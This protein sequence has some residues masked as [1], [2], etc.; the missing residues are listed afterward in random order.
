M[1]PSIVELGTQDLGV[2][3]RTIIAMVAAETL[4]PADEQITVKIGDNN[5]P[6][7]VPPAVRPRLAASR[8]STRKATVNALD[9][10]VRSGRVR[11]SNVPADQLEAVDGTIRVKGN[12]DKGMS[13]KQACQ[14][15][16]INADHR[17]GRERSAQQPEA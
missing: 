1:A 15:L 17:D 9:K 13:W 3:T 14:K 7:P 10:A 12:P 16:G 8:S 11:R 6:P 5:I 2:G 4:G